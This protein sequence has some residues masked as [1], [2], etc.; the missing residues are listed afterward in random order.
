MIYIQD[1]LLYIRCI[2]QSLGRE[3]AYICKIWPVNHTNISQ[4]FKSHVSR[5]FVIFVL[6]Y[7]L[8]MIKQYV[9]APPPPYNL[10]NIQLSGLFLLVTSNMLR[11][12]TVNNFLKELEH[13]L[14]WKFYFFTFAVINVWL[15][16]SNSQPN[17]T[18]LSSIKQ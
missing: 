16:Y 9:A 7:L 5:G 2:F 10:S 17:F 13:D 18:S 8:I 12:Q 14:N 3:V 6:F 15:R 4:D 11:K 1:V